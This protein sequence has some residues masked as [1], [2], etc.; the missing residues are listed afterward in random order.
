MRYAVL[1]DIHAN[2]HALDAV[3][4]AAER[5]RPDAY[6]S[7]GDVVGYGPY[8]NECVQRVTELEARCVLGNHEL[9]ALGRLSDIRCTPFARESLGWTRAQ[10]TD[11]TRAFLQEQPV[12][13]REGALVLA[14]GSLHDPEEYVR[15][16]DAAASQLRRLDVE[17][18]GARLL[19][20][21]HTHEQWAFSASAGTLLHQPGTVAVP[22]GDRALVNPGS[23]G[24]ARD[25]RAEARF[26]V[27]EVDPD[28]ARVTLHSVPYDVAGC[29]AALRERGRPVGSCHIRPPRR[30][31]ARALA[32][33]LVLRGQRPR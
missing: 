1:S 13:V 10:L 16:R 29:R 3:L 24:Q 26:A 12:R 27:L 28:A 8:P 20:L 25:S 17:E 30:E 21:G 22:A 18:P 31:R 23:V 5:E 4:A 19:L 15:S 6:L 7:L 11:N 14:H 32:R 9:I 2:L 33:R